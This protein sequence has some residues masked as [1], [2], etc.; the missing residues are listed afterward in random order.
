MFVIPAITWP[1]NIMDDP[2]FEKM[3]KPEKGEWLFQF[4]EGGQS[5][6]F[7]KVAG[8]ESGVFHGKMSL[9]SSIQQVIFSTSFCLEGFRLMQ[10]VIWL[11][12]W[13]IFT[14]KRIGILYL[15]RH[16]YPIG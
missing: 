12:P 15:A 13:L 14:Q 6:P 7:L 2:D 4:H 16:P 8:K 10:S 1:E 9:L 5:F 3:G 11:L